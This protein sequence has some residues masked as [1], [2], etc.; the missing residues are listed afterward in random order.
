MMGKNQKA[1][2]KAIGDFRVN[3][4]ADESVDRPVVERLREDSHAVTYVAGLA[5]SITDDAVL[6]EANASGRIGLSELGA[7][8]SFRLTRFR[9]GPFRALAV[10]TD[11]ACTSR[12]SPPPRVR[13]G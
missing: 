10:P 13:G 11:S 4:F 12:A 3:L 1:T 6:R 2:R 5:P 8:R 7:I 9:E